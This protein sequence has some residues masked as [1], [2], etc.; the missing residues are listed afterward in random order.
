MV[1]WLDEEHRRDRAEISRLQQQ[2]ESQTGDIVEQARRIQELEG[3]LASTTAQ[4][5]RFTQLEQQIES[6]KQEL[7]LMI[8][9]SDE[10]Q[11]QVARE[12]DRARLADREA[13][14]REISEVR[15]ELPR[16]GRI[17]EAVE[18]RKG[19]EERLVDMIMEGRNQ[20]NLL[21]KDLEERTRQ[22]PFLADQRTGDAKRIAQLQQ[23]TVELFKRTEAFSGRFSILEDA[24]RRMNTEIERWR[25]VFAEVREEQQQ[26][27]ERL[28]VEVVE[29]LQVLTRWQEIIDDQRGVV[30]KNEERLQSFAQSIETARRAANSIPEFQENMR[31][32]QV[33]VQE[34]QRLAEERVR[35]EMEEFEE[36]YEKKS[37][38]D[39]LR[40]EHLWREQE[41]NN[42]ELLDHLPPMLHDLR[43]HEEMLRLLWKLQEQ[44]GGRYINAAQLWLDGLQT[45]LEERDETMKDLEEEWQK[46]RRTA[47]LYA[48]QNNTAP[49]T[50]GIATGEPTH[51]RT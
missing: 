50:T 4:L 31:R 51:N 35:R 24:D 22:I 23:E 16:I 13:I 1:T 41:K 7:G 36:E 20:V 48:R 33:Q 2:I 26:F 18:L 39:G 42:K 3:R 5:G 17:E 49:R 30:A 14:S 15:R 9:R 32:D 21:V 46:Q 8:D 43:V 34:L 11:A 10:G 27:M 28:R 25:P 37:R 47:E 45:S 40:Q 19:E 38:R 6:V 29:R 12:F 44:Y